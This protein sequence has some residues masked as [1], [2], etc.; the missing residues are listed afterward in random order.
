MLDELQGYP[1][2]SDYRRTIE[3]LFREAD[4]VKFAKSLP[5]RSEAEQV[6]RSIQEQTKAFHLAWLEKQAK[7][8]AARKE[9]TE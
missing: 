5:Q 3:G 8:E 9:V 7:Q 4:F 2:S 6:T 1:L